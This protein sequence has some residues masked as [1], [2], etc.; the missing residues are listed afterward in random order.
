MSRPEAGPAKYT[1]PRDGI[2][3]IRPATP[4]PDPPNPFQQRRI[5]PPSATQPTLAPRV[6]PAGGDAQHPAHPGHPMMS[7]L[8]LHEAKRLYGLDSV[9]RAKKAAACPRGPHEVPPTSWGGSGSP[10]LPAGSGSPAAAAVT[11][12][13]PRSQARRYEAPRPAPPASP[14]CSGSP[15]RSQAPGRSARWAGPSSGPAELLPPGIPG[16]R[17]SAP[18]HCGLLSEA[19]ASSLKVSTKPGQVAWRGG[20]RRFRDRKVAAPLKPPSTRSC[21]ARWTR[22]P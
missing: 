7:P 20:A 2:C 18:R 4:L 12:P 21:S 10:A 5:L 6:V 9:S 22:F 17:G 19:V 16:V 14:T 13:A 11:P 3:P 1:I 15:R 8:L